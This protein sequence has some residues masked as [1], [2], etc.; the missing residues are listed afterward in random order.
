LR[1]ARAAATLIAC[2]LTAFL[3]LNYG[4]ADPAK[5][6]IIKALYAELQLQAAFKAYE[7]QSYVELSELIEEQSVLPSALFMEM[8]QKCVTGT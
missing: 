4:Q 6:T 8:L 1:R 5:V 7:Q 3:Q 2:Q